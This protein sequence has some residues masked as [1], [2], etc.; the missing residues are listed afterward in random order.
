MLAQRSEQFNRFGAVGM[1]SRLLNGSVLIVLADL[2]MVPAGLLTVAFLTRRLGPEGYGLFALCASL[3]AGL[4]WG[5]GSLLSR[6][7]IHGVGDAA[8]WRPVARAFL[9]WHLVIASAVLF[10]FWVLARPVAGLL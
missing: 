9:R 10:L 3:V 8:D 2:L 4:E 6:P 7:T 1:S 5:L